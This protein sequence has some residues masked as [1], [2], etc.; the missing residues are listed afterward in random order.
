MIGLE[1]EKAVTVDRHLELMGPADR[2]EAGHMTEMVRRLVRDDQRLPDLGACTRTDG[3]AF[4]I[5]CHLVEGA[6]GC[7]EDGA[8]PSDFGRRHDRLWSRS[9]RECGRAEGADQ[10]G[11]RNETTG[12]DSAV[13]LGS[14]NLPG[15]SGIGGSHR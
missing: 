15:P 4:G 12:D 2:A 10:D 14:P 13:R 6:V 9:A 5:V 8:Q 1:E 3:M 11:G 7:L